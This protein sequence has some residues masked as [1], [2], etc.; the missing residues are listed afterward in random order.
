MRSSGSRTLLPA[1][2][3]ATSTFTHLR[4]CLQNRPFQLLP[5]LHPLYRLHLLHY[6]QLLHLC[7]YSN[8][9]VI[10]VHSH[11]SSQ[12]SISTKMSVMTTPVARYSAWGRM[13]SLVPNSDAQ[14]RGCGDVE[15]IAD[16]IT[17][18]VGDSEDIPFQSCDVEGLRACRTSL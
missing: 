8:V 13:V 17:L 9:L 7:R 4:L 1:S 12:V 3:T 5:L 6:L 18:A 2:H 11:S 15:A 14:A 10:G 16:V